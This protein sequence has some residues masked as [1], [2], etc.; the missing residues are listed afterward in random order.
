MP[1]WPLPA[2]HPSPPAADD[3]EVIRQQAEGL[4]ANAARL[5]F[6][7]T[8]EQQPLRPLAMGNHETVVSVRPARKA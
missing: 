4:V 8:I 3:A 2:D 7:I 1:T 6:V 5:G